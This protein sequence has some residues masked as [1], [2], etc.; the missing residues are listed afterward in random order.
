MSSQ[1]VSVENFLFII[2]LDENGKLCYQLV[3]TFFVDCIAVIIRR[4]F[5]AKLEKRINF[6]AC[7]YVF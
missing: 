7:Q 4:I 3:L 1:L 6:Y 5:I 2:N